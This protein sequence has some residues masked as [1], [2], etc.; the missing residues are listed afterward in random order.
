MSKP[1]S[2]LRIL[3][4][5]LENIRFGSNI[6]DGLC[7]YYLQDVAINILEWMKNVWSVIYLKVLH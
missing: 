7:K 3:S 2:H 5:F 4:H 1:S 6:E